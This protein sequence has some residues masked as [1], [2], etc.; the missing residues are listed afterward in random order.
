MT[1][2]ITTHRSN[3]PLLI[4]NMWH[5]SVV[6]ISRVA[7]TPVDSKWVLWPKFPSKY[8]NFCT[9][10]IC[11][12]MMWSPMSLQHSSNVASWADIDKAAMSR[13]ASVYVNTTVTSCPASMSKKLHHVLCQHWHNLDGTPSIIRTAVTSHLR[14][15]LNKA[16]TS[17][18][19]SH[20]T[21]SSNYQGGII[22]C[23]TRIHT[24]ARTGQAIQSCY[25]SQW[26]YLWP[27]GGRDAAGE[28]AWRR[29]QVS[30]RSCD[31]TSVCQ[32]TSAPTWPHAPRPGGSPPTGRG[33]SGSRW[34]AG[35]GR[36][37]LCAPLQHTYT[38]QQVTIGENG[39]ISTSKPTS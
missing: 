21:T 14:L 12:A 22:R 25:T 24:R 11:T 35:A 4:T 37:A 1:K 26:P 28:V 34:T 20:D 38:V 10:F 8:H 16:V 19:A 17:R 32:T 13:L 33:W 23:E 36:G 6:H 29:R 7:W 18:P 3:D 2:Y 39:F 27:S 9:V 30:Q 15:S 5:D 31:S